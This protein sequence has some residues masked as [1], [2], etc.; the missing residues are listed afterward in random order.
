MIERNSEKFWDA[1][2]KAGPAQQKHLMHLMFQSLIVTPDG[3]DVF[4][5]TTEDREAKDK[6]APGSSPGAFLSQ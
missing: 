1:W 3:I 2:G 5:W 6:K 4:Y